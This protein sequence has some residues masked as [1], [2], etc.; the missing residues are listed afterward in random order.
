MEDKET[1]LNFGNVYFVNVWLTHSYMDL[2]RITNILFCLFS[3]M[4]EIQDSLSVS[5]LGGGEDE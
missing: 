2:N 4:T 5:G 3:K 1:E